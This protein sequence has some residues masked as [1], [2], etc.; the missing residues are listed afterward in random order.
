MRDGCNRTVPVY[1]PHQYDGCKNALPL[2]FRLMTSISSS[3]KAQ[4]MLCRH[5]SVPGVGREALLPRSSA[6]ENHRPAEAAR[7]LLLM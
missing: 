3:S 7:D 4:E 6:I 2:T 1:S 5:C